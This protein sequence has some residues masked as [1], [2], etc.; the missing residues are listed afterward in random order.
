[1]VTL[2]KR[3][4]LC[5]LEDI[6]SCKVEESFK[7]LL[8]PHPLSLFGSVL[9]VFVNDVVQH[10]DERDLTL[11]TECQGLPLLQLKLQ[12]F[13]EAHKF[14]VVEVAGYPSHKNCRVMFLADIILERS[15]FYIAD[16]LGLL[17]KSLDDLDSFWTLI[18]QVYLLE[19]FM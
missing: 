11:R 6:Q 2:D 18:D 7:S 19:P 1:M 3:L 9:F 17:F 14:L 13:E 16:I 12:V 4:P 10:K 5:L 15:L 8:G